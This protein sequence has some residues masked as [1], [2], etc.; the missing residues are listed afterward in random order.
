MLTYYLTK[1]NTL[2]KTQI[3]SLTELRI[4]CTTLFLL[5]E[6]FQKL[7]SSNIT[8]ENYNICTNFT[9]DKRY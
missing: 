4:K 5:L 8:D 1:I 9:D 2:D 7:F 6:F 3:P